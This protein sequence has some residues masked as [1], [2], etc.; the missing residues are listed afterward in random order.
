MPNYAGLPK[1][2]IIAAVEAA[3]DS[4]TLNA[5]DADLAREGWSTEGV[6]RAR[7]AQRHADLAAPPSPDVAA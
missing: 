4:D 5:I 6:I 3:P 1:D 2:E 7:I